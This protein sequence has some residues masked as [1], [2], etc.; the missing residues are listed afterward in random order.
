MGIVGLKSVRRRVMLKPSVYLVTSSTS[1]QGQDDRSGPGI[2]VCPEQIQVRRG[3][4]HNAGHG[5][6][7][8]STPKSGD[9]QDTMS[10]ADPTMADVKD[11]ETAAVDLVISVIIATDDGPRIGRAGT[12]AG[13]SS[14]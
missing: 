6:G 7:V 1:V 11:N 13:T 9:G 14:P 4:P 12:T 10:L 2:D 8:H 5:L 3:L